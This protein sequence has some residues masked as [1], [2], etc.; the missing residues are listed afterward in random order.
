MLSLQGEPNAIKNIQEILCLV[1]VRRFPWPSWS[2]R[3]GDVSEVNG[4]VPPSR[5]RLD[6]VTRNELPA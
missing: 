4:R 6:H 2:I 3:F 1:P 5:L